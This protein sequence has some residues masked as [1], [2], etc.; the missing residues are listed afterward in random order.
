M[1]AMMT[2]GSGRDPHEVLREAAAAGDVWAYFLLGKVYQA[3]GEP[4]IAAP[5]VQ[6]AAEHGYLQAQHELAH[7]YREGAGVDQSWAMT[8]SWFRRAAEQ[9]H[10]DSQSALAK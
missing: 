4:V 3:E 9:G 10:A 5:K 6:K 2:D 8:A 1:R 7:D